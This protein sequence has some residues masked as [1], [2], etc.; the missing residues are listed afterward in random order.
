MQITYSKDFSPGNT[1]YS[2]MELNIYR[3]DKVLK[4][5]VS[6]NNYTKDLEI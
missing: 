5:D 6:K 1:N 4:M 3:K 2:Q